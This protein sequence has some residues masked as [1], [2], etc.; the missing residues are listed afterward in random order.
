ML[1]RMLKPVVAMATVMMVAAQP[2]QAA[3]PIQSWTAPSGAKVMF[4]QAEALPM[5]DIRVDLPAGSR[6][7]PQGKEG[8]AAAVGDMI[9]RGA[10]GLTENQI[11]DGFADTGAQFSGGASSDSAGFS[12]RTLTSEPEFSKSV[13]LFKTVLQRPVFIGDILARENA[14]AVSSLKESL[15]KPDTLADRAFSQ[16]LYPNHPYGALVTETSLKAITLADVEQFYKSRYLAKHAVVSIVGN[17][18]RP[19]AEKLAAEL[20]ANLQPGTLQGNPLGGQDF[21]ALQAAMRGQTIQIDH[22]AAQS[23][24]L[25]GLPAMRRGAPDYFDLL[26]ANHV[27]GG[28]GFNSRLM[29]EIREKRGLAYSAYSYFMPA[30]D[31]GPFQAGVQTQKSQTSEAL[32]LMRKTIEEF[33]AKGPT[34]AE[35]NA[36]KANLIGG[37]PLR[38]DSNS[39]LVSNISMMG[40]HNMPLDYLDNWTQEVEKVTVESARKAFAKHVNPSKLVTVVVGGSV[41][42]PVKP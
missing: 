19:Q 23:H 28:G 38:I 5:V 17:V 20:T 13:A 2:A 8:L 7:D 6:A 33:I 4:M 30:G 16:A 10:Q 11:A 22:P 42:A 1:S 9:G 29:D 3:L 40:L 36:A 31:A 39:K 15:T 14:R 27:L 34:Q 32:T 26:V 37:F 24:I 21:P 41:E 12:L 35:L 25:M 18:S